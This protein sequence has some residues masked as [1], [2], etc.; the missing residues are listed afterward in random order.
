MSGERKKRGAI[1]A[2]MGA[3]TRISKTRRKHEMT[4][5]QELGAELVALNDEQLAGIELPEILRDA[6]L[7]ARRI[8]D[9]E[10]RRR[11]LQYVGKL[12][13]KVDA[14]PI[15]AQLDRWKSR[16]RLKSQQFQRAEAWRER[17]LSE[18]GALAG[19]LQEFPAAD[20]NELHRLIE[21]A[22]RERTQG[23]PPR[24]YRALFQALRAIL[25]PL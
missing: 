5:L 18:E 14:D 8:T 21:S 10:G 11:Q 13:R 23:Q 22:R 19:F 12:M 17:L 3:D 9:F 7:E 1:I 16:S 20:A 24:S 4:A 2:V 15:R 6:V 25:P